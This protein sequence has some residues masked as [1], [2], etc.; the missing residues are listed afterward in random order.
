MT[1]SQFSLLAFAVVVAALLVVVLRMIWRVRTVRRALDRNNPD[2]AARE[3][4]FKDVGKRAGARVPDEVHL[5]P[6]QMIIWKDQDKWREDYKALEECGFRHVGN[7]R[8]QEIGVD[9]EFLMNPE[10]RAQACI[11]N[12]PV[13]GVFMDV[14]TRY[15]DGTSVTFA[16]RNATGLDQ[17]PKYQNRFLGEIPAAELVERALRERPD[18]AKKPVREEDL[19]PDFCRVWK[20]YKKWRSSRGTTPEEVGRIYERIQS[21]EQEK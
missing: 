18:W 7:Y 5:T 14:V 10:E 1:S 9:V 17:H 19:V 20:E 21:K 4:V 12:H 13:V 6:I 3:K 8:V 2:L 16:N 15:E 11:Y